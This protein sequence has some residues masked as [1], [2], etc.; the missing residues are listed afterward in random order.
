MVSNAKAEEV[1]SQS[2]VA[3]LVTFTAVTKGGS[4]AAI[5]PAIINQMLSVSDAPPEFQFA[6]SFAPARVLAALSCM[7]AALSR[8]SAFA[9]AS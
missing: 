8:Q 5:L 6:S 2:L 9:P 4:A 7:P 1:G 3:R